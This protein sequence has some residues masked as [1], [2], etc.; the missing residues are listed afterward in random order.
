M[1]SQH[2]LRLEANQSWQAGLNQLQDLIN[3]IEN[4]KDLEPLADFLP[5]ILKTTTMGYDGKG[6][7]PIKNI[8]Q[9]SSLNIDFYSVALL[10]HHE[11]SGNKNIYYN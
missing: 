7:Y 8:E 6:Q 1:D 4:K 9:I 5:G 10:L 11:L 2:P 3:A